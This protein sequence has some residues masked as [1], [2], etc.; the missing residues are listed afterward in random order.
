MQLLKLE[1]RLAKY[2][3]GGYLQKKEY[4][5]KNK[6]RIKAYQRNRYKQDER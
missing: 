3:N 5:Q 4:Y 1:I 2:K 6:E